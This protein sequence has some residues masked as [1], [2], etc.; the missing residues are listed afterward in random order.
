ME[1]EPRVVPLYRDEVVGRRWYCLHCDQHRFDP[2]TMRLHVKQL[3]DV[4]N[5]E[6]GE[7][8]AEGYNVQRMQLRRR[9]WIEVKAERFALAMTPDGYGAE[10]LLIDVGDGVPDA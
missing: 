2:E 1:L 4:L 3:H 10:D 7:D 6:N 9:L 8:Y 5:P